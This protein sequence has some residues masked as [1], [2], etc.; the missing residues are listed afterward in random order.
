MDLFKSIIKRLAGLPN[1]I[2]KASLKKKL[3]I[4]AVI[5]AIG[6]FGGTR[7]QSLGQQQP[8]YQTAQAEK[9]SLITSVTASGTVSQASGASITTQATGIV[10]NVYVKDGDIITAGQRIA[11]ITL[12]VTSSQKQAAAWASY[13]SAKNSL[14]SAQN[15]LNSLNSTMWQ[16][17]QDLIK[18]AVA[19]GLTTDNPTYIQQNSD[20]LKAENDYKNQQNIITASKASLNSS[21]LS[22]S[23]LSRTVTAPMSGR[24]SGLSLAPGMSITGTTSPTSLGTITIEGGM[25]QVSVNL[26]EIDV[27]KVKIGQKVILTLDALPDKSFTGV[28]VVV[29]TNGSVSSNVTTYPATITFDTAVD[30][31]YPNMAVNAT[32]ITDVKNNVILI[33]SGALQTSNGQSTVRV[34]RDNS[35]RGEAGQ[36]TSVSV[37]VGNSNDTQTEIISGINEGDIV[38]TGETTTTTTGTSGTGA[39]SP[40]GNTRGG[41]G[42][43]GGFGGAQRR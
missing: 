37:E 19:R 35:P 9:G 31:I 13:L 43:T 30:T 17:Q 23:Q 6:W 2:L 25:P 38:I 21:W 27:V 12:D 29:N 7:I 41:F 3:A 36:E 39:T 4:L 32:I 8:T 24:V 28:V 15:S 10:S 40:F 20:W 42:G 11:D 33:P 18:D 16:V 1:W 26:T 34:M 14:A 5:L 22:Y